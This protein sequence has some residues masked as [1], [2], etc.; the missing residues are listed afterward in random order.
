MTLE[1]FKAWMEGFEEAIEDNPT[2][3]QW[4]KIKEKLSMVNN[5]PHTIWVDRYI[6]PNWKD[7]WYHREYIPA[8]WDSITCKT[9]SSNTNDTLVGDNLNTSTT[10]YFDSIKA[11]GRIEATT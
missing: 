1:E 9:L 4:K 5:I 2:P 10:S 11:E 3:K 6:H 7:Y 8:R